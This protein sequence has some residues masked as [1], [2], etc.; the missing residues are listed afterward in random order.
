MSCVGLQCDGGVIHL[1]DQLVQRRHMCCSSV[2]FSCQQAWKQYRKAEVLKNV[3]SVEQI[4]S[5]CIGCCAE[6]CLSLPSD[7]VDAVSSLVSVS[8]WVFRCR[9]WPASM[10]HRLCLNMKGRRGEGPSVAQCPKLPALEK[11]AL[12]SWVLCWDAEMRSEW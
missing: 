5:V 6:R 2:S 9:L 11:C 7:W 1:L 12:S 8:I 3:I 10:C 4:V